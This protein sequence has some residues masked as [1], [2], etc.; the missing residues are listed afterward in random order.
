MT[1]REM[2]G[3]DVAEIRPFAGAPVHGL[4]TAR[5]EGAARWGVGGTRYVA[6]QQNAVT[7]G[8]GCGR[9]HRGEKRLGMR[10]PRIRVEI[11][12]R[13]DFHYAALIHHSYPI[14]QVPHDP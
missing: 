11:C 12:R 8:V 2:A 3:S 5:M 1:G 6:P 14:G 7:V 9:G 13:P 4:G 10:V